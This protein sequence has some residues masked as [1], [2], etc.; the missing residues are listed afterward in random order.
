M[1]DGATTTCSGDEPVRKGP[2]KGVRPP[3]VLLIVNPATTLKAG[4]AAYRNLPAG[5]TAKPP[6]IKAGT[7]NGE[8]LITERLPVL[9]MEKASIP[10]G[11][12]SAA[13]KTFPEGVATILSA[14]LAPGRVVIGV[15]AAVLVL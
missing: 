14:P 12:S 15:T 2:T 3:V 13:Y 7:G 11:E 8:P 6:T 9:L 4:L 10:K 1:P 5:S